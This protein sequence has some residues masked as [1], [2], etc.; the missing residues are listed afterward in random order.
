MQK[1]PLEIEAHIV[2]F[3]DP[4]NPKSIVLSGLYCPEKWLNISKFLLTHDETYWWFEACKGGH[5]EVVKWLHENRPECCT[6][7]AMDWAAEHGHL[8]V[9]KW[10]QEKIEN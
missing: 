1:L 9:V 7:R 10:L 3:C 2:S 4:Q 8:E 5:L 6:V